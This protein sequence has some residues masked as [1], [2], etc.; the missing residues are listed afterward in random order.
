MKIIV[1]KN[2]GFCFGVNRAVETV[3]NLLNENHKICTLGPI[4][5][6][7]QIVEDL[8]D[9]GVKVI[10]TPEETP[11]NYTLIIRSH[12]VSKSVIDKIKNLKINY[13]DVTCPFVKKI[14]SL[15][16]NKN[17]PVFIFGDKNHAEVIGIAGH[18]TNKIYIFNNSS[19]LAETIKKGIIP[20]DEKIIVV[21]QTTFNVEEWKKCS[22]ILKKHCTN[23]EIFDTICN[24]TQIR[25]Q[26]A[27]NLAKKSDLMLIVGGKKS[28]N[29]LKL[30]TV[31]DKFCN[32]ILIESAKDI[33]NNL[34]K[35]LENVG[36]TAGAS[37]P[38]Y[39]ILEV[40]QKMEEILKNEQENSREE[41]FEEMLE[42]SLKNM[43]TS[44]YVKGTVVSV[45]PSE[46]CV[47]IGRKHAGFIPA[48]ELSND[49]NLKPEDIVKVGDVLD[50]LILKTNDQDGTIMLSKKKV[51][52]VKGFDEI[53]KAYEEKTILSGKIVD[54]VNGG[55]I[56]LYKGIRVFIPS[57]L[58]SL[59]KNENLEN[60]KGQTVNFRIIESDKS[61]RRII[62][63]IKSVLLDEKKK[64]EE[65]FWSTANVGD[66]LE[67]EVVSFK[68]YGAFVNLG[69]VDGM[70]H[71]SEL[72]WTKVKHPSDVL[73]L[74]EKIP[75]VIID[76]DKEN[77]RVALSFKQGQENPWDTFEK[78]Y[79]V[80]DLIDVTIV[81]LTD[82][83]A[84]A[85]II[86]G[87]DGL[88]HISQISDKRI[89]HP[90]DVLSIGDI[91]K[92][93]ITD[94]DLEN[95]RIGLSMI[96]LDDDNLSL[97]SSQPEPIDSDDNAEKVSENSD[98]DN[99]LENVEVATEASEI[100]DLDEN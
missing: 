17:C 88:I 38:T 24:T 25:Q 66:K 29:T 73:T 22:A 7:P 14:H 31:C 10:D 80:G 20:M 82:F 35:N 37:T 78:N 3:Y 61:R 86:P 6:N 53:S 12:G 8:S 67:G 43:D 47:D 91:V 45:S 11:E 56:S 28:S 23:C 96:N 59:R 84:F 41:N 13:V 57:S 94:V 68:P 95:R 21:Q 63:S 76:L 30:K 93:K 77:N 42:E 5:H 70:I 90:K 36:I 54:I 65:E 83:G 52:S 98:T 55:V 60:L 58:T 34:P 26:E 44:R 40:K 85:K 100:S 18:C 49:P 71:I 1:A 51:D 48:S 89:K 74:G 27:A 97:E 50:L 69:A 19:E 9:K 62:G 16:Y 99:S 64:K 32:T 4:I 75:V 46:V 39:I 2:A 33:P 15:V 81:N 72:S 87:I 79:S 92:A